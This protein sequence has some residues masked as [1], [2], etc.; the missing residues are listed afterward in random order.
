MAATTSQPKNGFIVRAES[1]DGGKTWSEGQNSAF[2]NP[3]SAIE[4]LKLKSG[5]LLLVFN[6]SMTSRTPL[7]AAL[8][9]DG[10]K[11]YPHRRNIVE[12]RNSF[13]YPIGFQAATA[14][15][16]SST[17]PISGR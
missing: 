13:A 3:N 2:P 8:S 5:A 4:F 9:T 6:D 15:S 12:G 7:T 10:D 16:T 1:H 11:T 17:R 14:A